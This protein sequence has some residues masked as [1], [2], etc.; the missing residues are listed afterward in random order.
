MQTAGRAMPSAMTSWAVLKRK[1]KPDILRNFEVKAVDLS[2][3]V[4]LLFRQLS[5]FYRD[6]DRS[7]KVGKTGEISRRCEI[8]GVHNLQNGTGNDHC[9]G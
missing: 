3:V 9:F 4:F 6:I 2:E 5:F 7:S 1:V 8:L